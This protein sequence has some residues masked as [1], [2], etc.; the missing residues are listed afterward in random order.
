MVRYGRGPLRRLKWLLD[1]LA[2]TGVYLI[3]VTVV[4]DR[5]GEVPALSV[6]CAVVPFQL[7]MM[8]V[9]A[10]LRSVPDR[11]AIVQNMAFPR[12]LIPVAT[13]LAES[14][15]FGV[16]VLMLGVLMAVYGI[17]PTPALT[18]LPVAIAVTAALALALAYASA[19]IGLWVPEMQPFVISA[20]R[21]LFFLAPSVVA[22]NEVQGGSRDLLAINPLSGLFEAYRS[23][24]IEGT[25]PAAWQLLV[26]LAWAAAIAAVAVPVFRREQVHFAKLVG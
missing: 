25:A 11:A 13:T 10:G 14:V 15:G 26:P 12:T 17:A 20:T 16:C 22:L 4:V 6:A 21:T 3:L 7:V 2:A 1:P 5:A 24:L 9:V 23:I 19:L 8:S 18:L